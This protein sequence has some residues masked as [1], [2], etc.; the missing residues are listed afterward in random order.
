MSGLI[1]GQDL[2]AYMHDMRAF[3][4]KQGIKSSISLW[5][6]KDVNYPTERG[7][8]IIE[9]VRASSLSKR[10]MSIDYSVDGTSAFYVDLKTRELEFVANLLFLCSDETG[11]LWKHYVAL[12]ED[13]SGN[14]LYSKFFRWDNWTGFH[15][16]NEMQS[17]EALLAKTPTR[18]S[19][20]NFIND[21]S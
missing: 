1:S 6:L 3:F 8:I 12:G 11:Q 15:L 18:F 10:K 17:L 7:A 5:R 13:E 20:N 4:D 2:T 21:R 14:T 16:L 19:G 9:S